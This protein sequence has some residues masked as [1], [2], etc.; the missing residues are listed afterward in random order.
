[1]LAVVHFCA[2][3]PSTTPPYSAPLLDLSSHDIP[4]M[5][6][7]QW[8]VAAAKSYTCPQKLIG[9]QSKQYLTTHTVDQGTDAST[10]SSP[11]VQPC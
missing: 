4:H 5:G 6:S 8:Y 2:N 11:F 10:S 9:K 7:Q 1:M 3:T